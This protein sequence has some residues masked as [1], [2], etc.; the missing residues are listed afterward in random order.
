MPKLKLDPHEPGMLAEV[1]R[2]QLIS[3]MKLPLS[4]FRFS[5][6]PRLSKNTDGTRNAAKA[7]LHP[8]AAR[9]LCQWPPKNRASNV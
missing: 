3:E 8:D 1:L 9:L 5:D 4:P 2:H 7:K 6:S